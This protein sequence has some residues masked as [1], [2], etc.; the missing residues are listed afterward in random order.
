M[1]KEDEGRLCRRWKTGGGFTTKPSAKSV[2]SDFTAKTGNSFKLVKHYR[3]QDMQKYFL[4]RE[5]LTCG[6]VWHHMLLTH[7]QLTVL[8]VKYR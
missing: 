6:T 2:L 1:R 8:R 3:K 5:L 7:V 4:L